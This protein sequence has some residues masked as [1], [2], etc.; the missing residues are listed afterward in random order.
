M[1]IHQQHSLIFIAVHLH[2]H[3]VLFSIT[4]FII[5][6][7]TKYS[8]LPFTSIPW[9]FFYFHIQIFH[10]NHSLLLPHISKCLRSHTGYGTVKLLMIYQ[11]R[12]EFNQHR[13]IAL[14]SNFGCPI[15]VYKVYPLEPTLPTVMYH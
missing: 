10:Q 5:S 6:I 11:I 8:P 7:I 2:P 3:E 1:L 12:K 4:F 13:I 14:W 15:Q 9:H